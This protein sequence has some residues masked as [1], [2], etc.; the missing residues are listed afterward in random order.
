MTNWSYS[1]NLGLILLF[2][3][4]CSFAFTQS[5]LYELVDGAELGYCQVD[6]EG[7]LECTRA[8]LRG[9]FRIDFFQSTSRIEGSVVDL[10]FQSISGP[11]YTISG[12]GS[13][14][15]APN[16]NSPLGLPARGAMDLGLE[17]NE[18][19]VGFTTEFTKFQKFPHIDAG[20]FQSNFPPHGYGIRI[21]A[22]PMGN[23]AMRFFRRADANGDTEVNITDA[24]VIL[25]MLF[26]GGATLDCEDAADS[27]DDGKVDLS[28]C[29][30]ILKYLFDGASDLPIPA[31]LCGLDPSDDSLG[32]HG[33]LA[34]ISE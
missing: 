4:P 10:S 20:L 21:V 15:I 28:D 24:V 34:C 33:Q 16:L 22:Q 14:L 5:V 25:D 17:I 18:I 9:T 19:G 30:R 7:N 27:N 6:P 29:V 2:I 31:V 11:E 32:C 26:I 12:G 3:V 23:E 13:Y 1:R 8:A